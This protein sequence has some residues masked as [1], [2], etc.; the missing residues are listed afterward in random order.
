MNWLANNQ[1]R[2]SDVKTNWKR[3]VVPLMLGHSNVLCVWGR[4]SALCWTVERQTCYR[5]MYF[6]CGSV[7]GCEY[8]V[9]VWCAG[10]EWHKCASEWHICAKF[11]MH[12]AMIRTKYRMHRMLHGA[13]CTIKL[14]NNK[15]IEMFRHAH[16]QYETGRAS[17][18]Q[19]EIFCCVSF[20]SFDLPFVSICFQ[21]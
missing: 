21:V 6:I 5:N 2:R 9:T 7:T 4:I 17:D 16:T 12:S 20:W 13:R 10:S 15:H 18:I 1:L 19:G 14:L 8:C 3:S 11:C